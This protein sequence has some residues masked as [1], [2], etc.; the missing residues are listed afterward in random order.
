MT[1]VNNS[2]I[3][4]DLVL[5]LRTEEENPLAPDGIEC[6]EIKPCDDADESLL[7]SVHPD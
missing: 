3:S 5:D 6:L 4:A 2:S 7:H 1:V